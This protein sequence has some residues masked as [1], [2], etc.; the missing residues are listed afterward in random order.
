MQI[1][2]IV[3]KI[4]TSKV[5]VFDYEILPEQL[6]DI[7]IGVLVLIPFHGRKI[8]GVI[9]EIKK[10]SKLQHLKPIIKIMDPIP[11]IDKNH[12]ELARWMANYYLAPLG[13]TIFSAIVPPA[14]RSIRNAQHFFAKTIIIKRKQTKNYLL[15]ADFATRLKFYKQALKQTLANNLSAII[16]VPDLTLIPFFQLKDAV[17]LHAGLSKSARWQAWDKI[18]SGNVKIVIGSQSALFS[19]VNNLGL[20]I[21][22]QEENET[23]KND[24]VPRFLASTTALR[25]GKI[26]H[27]D[28]IL[29]SVM[30]TLDSFVLAKENKLILKQQHKNSIIPITI[31]DLN[32]QKNFWGDVLESRIRKNLLNQKKTLLFLD[33]KG[34]GIKYTCFDC[35][36]VF[37]CPRCDIPLIPFNQNASVHCFRCDKNYPIPLKCPNCQSQNLKPLGITTGWIAKNI[38]NLFPKARII[39]IESKTNNNPFKNNWDIAIATSFALKFRF[40]Q[41]DLVAILDADQGLAIP[42]FRSSEKTFRK[43]YKFLKISKNGLIQ[44]HFPSS[45]RINALAKLDYEAFFSYEYATRKKYLFPPQCNLIRLVYKNSDEE[46]AISESQKVYQN[47]TALDLTKDVIISP[48]SQAFASKKNDYYRYQ[49][50]IKFQAKRSDKL[51]RY[52][53][54]LSQ[55]WQV[56]VDPQNLV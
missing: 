50:I 27:A 41:I 7:K 17:L 35:N 26:C 53:I 22:D 51:A 14:I 11:V 34:E 19:P 56:D 24:R 29:G 30:P 1:A 39:R 21:I 9:V 32:T 47:L 48:P 40:P 43:L 8:E 23:Y 5:S 18:R 42:D 25:L 12:L 46:K 45:P 54:S 36:W 13:K 49:I 4:S 15:V 52:L 38:K 28:V 20:V 44:T 2:K 37:T 31:I 16:L 3:P 6:V 55:G 10:T 33:R